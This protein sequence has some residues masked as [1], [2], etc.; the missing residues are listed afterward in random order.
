M[1]VASNTTCVDFGRSFLVSTGS[2]GA[3]DPA[4]PQNDVRF[5]VESVLTLTDERAGSAWTIYQCASCKAENTFDAAGPG[6]LFKRPNYDYLPIVCG[7]EMLVLRRGVLAEATRYRSCYREPPTFGRFGRLIRD[8]VVV[9]VGAVALPDFKAVAA[10]SRSGAPLVGR[11]LLTAP[12]AG[13][14]AELEY[15][16]KTL[17]VRFTPDVYQVD[18]GPVLFPDL[19]VRRARW[20]D[21]LHLAFVAYETR[22]AG[23]ADFILE[24]ETPLNAAAVA[25]RVLHFSRHLSRPAV[26]SLWRLA[27][28]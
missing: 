14:R 7:A 16:I 2:S 23:H 18:T 25:P 6:D 27:P 4:Q 15:P 12:E 28:S 22:T 9:A 1:A 19:D 3:G 21:Y 24:V 13:L 26:N 8:N 17:N 20:A 10:A 5:Q 11:S